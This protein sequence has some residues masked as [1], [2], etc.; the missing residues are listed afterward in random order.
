MTI[1]DDV[2]YQILYSMCFNNKN[3]NKRYMIIYRY[4]DIL[5]YKYTGIPVAG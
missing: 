3:K 4:I 1:D 2:N 5:G